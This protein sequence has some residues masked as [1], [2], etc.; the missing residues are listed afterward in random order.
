MVDQLAEIAG[1][2]KN[3]A[4]W[5]DGWRF[6][7]RLAQ[8]WID[9]GW[10]PDLCI[11]AAKSVMAT[12]RDGPPNSMKYFQPAIERLEAQLTEHGELKH[13]TAGRR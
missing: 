6:A 2:T 11:R 1:L 3:S 8:S 13:A 4:S 9:R 12:K 10:T 7:Q 5:S